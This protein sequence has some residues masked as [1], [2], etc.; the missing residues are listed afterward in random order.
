MRVDFQ[1][2]GLP[3][4]PS[5]LRT[6]KARPLP[7]NQ[8]ETAMPRIHGGGGSSSLTTISIRFAP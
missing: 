2:I 8:R 7:I 3:F 1:F 6:K 4:F 5:V